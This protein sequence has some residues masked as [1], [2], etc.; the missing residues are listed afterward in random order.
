VLADLRYGH[1]RRQRY[2]RRID[3]TLSKA[4]PTIKPEELAV[5]NEVTEEDRADHCWSLSRRYVV[6]AVS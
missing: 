3:I 6:Q 5:A 2:G 4:F 1:V